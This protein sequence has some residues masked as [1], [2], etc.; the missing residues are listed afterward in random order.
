VSH[1]KRLLRV[2]AILLT[3]FC[4]L[5]VYSQADLAQQAKQLFEQERWPGLVEL[6]EQAPRTS[7]DLDYYYGVAL[8]HQQ[9]W[10]EARQSLAAGQQLAPRDKRFPIELAGVAFKQKNYDRARSEL[11]RAVRLDAGDE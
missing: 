7:A 5:P 3:A 11:R 10:E 4:C 6:L 9:R 1:G 8:A 2:F